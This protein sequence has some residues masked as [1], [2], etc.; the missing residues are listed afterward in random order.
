MSIA[1]SMHPESARTDRDRPGDPPW[2]AGLDLPAAPQSAGIAR[3]FAAARLAEWG[4]ADL[5]DDVDL[6]I[7]ELIT[8]ALLH[9]RTQ[10]RSDPEAVVRLD[11]EYDRDGEALVCRVADG[12]PL[13]PTPE[14]A[15]DTAESGRG[16]LLV[17]ALSS[18]WGW[19]PVPGGGKVV[20][21]R[22]ELR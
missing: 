5:S 22:F 11:L 14:Q 2:A 10:L 16:L 7:S 4:L 1:T 21:A 18:A 20:W 8:N 19:N 9:A 3:R 13:P 17:E 6:I 12:S 15:A